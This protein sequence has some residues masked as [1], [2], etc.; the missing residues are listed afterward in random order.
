M[1]LQEAKHQLDALG[2]QIIGVAAREDYQAQKLLDDGITFPLLIDAAGELRAAIG[3]ASPLSVARLLD[4]RGALAYAKSISTAKR[5][6]EITPSQATRRPGT[7]IFDADLELVWHHIGDRLGDYKP[8]E[9]VLDQ[10][11]RL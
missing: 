6:F 7:A 4:P 10:L 3:S 1:Q 2:V 5:F 8:L 9:A 11:T